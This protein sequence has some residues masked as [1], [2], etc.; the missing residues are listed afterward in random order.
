MRKLYLAE[1]P[2]VLYLAGQLRGGENPKGAV[3][4]K[5]PVVHLSSKAV[6]L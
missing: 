2:F 6:G 4:R 1:F 5:Q 3:N